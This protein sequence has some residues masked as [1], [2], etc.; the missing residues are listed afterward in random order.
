MKIAIINQHFTDVL[1]GSEIQCDIIAK[2]LT[3]LGHEVI[4]HVQSPRHKD[5]KA[6]YRTHPLNKP[7]YWN[8]WKTLK[9]QRPD[10]VYWRHNKKG[11]TPFLFASKL[12]RIPFVYSVSSVEDSKLFSKPRRT[13]QKLSVLA[14]MLA[15]SKNFIVHAFIKLFADGIVCLSKDTAN[16]LKSPKA[17]LIYNSMETQ[18]VNFQ[19]PRPY[20][21]WV[22]NLKAIKNPELFYALSQNESF[23]EIDFLMVGKITDPHYE[24]FKDL[25]STSNN[26]HYLGPR[27]PAEVNGILQSSMF[28]IHT[29]DP[30]GFGN[31]F[32]QA[33]FAAK[34]TI[35]L[36]FDPDG[37]IKSNHLGY[38][39]LTFE[40]LENDARTLIERPET[41]HKIGNNALEFAKLNFTPEVNAR[42]LETFLLRLLR[43]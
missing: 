25:K 2:E 24:Y 40:Q 26:F 32:I 36:Y 42:K 33:W 13:T 37:L 38:H 31:I 19:W 21:A 15:I 10:I 16:Q 43:T 41:R 11:V 28:L 17:V 12:L 5:Y 8:A 29:C 6:P 1:G 34:P 23:K 4:Y 3:K 39:S 30:E 18:A 9:N 7:G 22:A 20:V 14:Y 27:T 35:S